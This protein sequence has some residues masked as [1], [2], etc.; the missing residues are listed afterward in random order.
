MNRKLLDLVDECYLDKVHT[1]K[2]CLFPSY[3]Q[4]D[5]LPHT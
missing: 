3:M 2:T 4:P 5:L 1:V